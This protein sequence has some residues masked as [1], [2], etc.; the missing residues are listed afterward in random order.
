MVPLQVWRWDRLGGALLLKAQKP[1]M[2]RGQVW[3]ADPPSLRP[4]TQEHKALLSRP[5]GEGACACPV[6][7]SAATSHWPMGLVV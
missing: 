6:A 3:L 4:L 5:A 1:S 7:D 2:A